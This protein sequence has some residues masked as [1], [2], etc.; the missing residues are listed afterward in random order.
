MRLS[1]RIG[2]A[3]VIAGAIL[4]S[5]MTVSAQESGPLRKGARG[6]CNTIFGCAELLIQPYDVNQTEGGLACYTY[7]VGKGISCFLAREGVGVFE[8][9]T[10]PMPLPGLTDSPHEVGW[11]Y[12]PIL[13]PEWVVDPQHDIYNLVYQDFPVD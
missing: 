6:F 3:A 5:S 8:I 13:E 4:A 7:G 11:G 2:L 10:A 1:K 12:A 9:I